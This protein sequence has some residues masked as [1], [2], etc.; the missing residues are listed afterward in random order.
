[1]RNILFIILLLTASA[2]P[3]AVFE[4]VDSDIYAFLERQSIRGL[5]DFRYEIK[6]VLKSL[7]VKELLQLSGKREELTSTDRDLLERYLSEFDYEAKMVTDKVPDESKSDFITP[8]TKRKIRLFEHT[9]GEFAMFADPMLE[10]SYRKEFDEFNFI[11][12]NGFR[13]HGY[14]MK[15]W[16]F[17]IRFF[18]N[19]EVTDKPDYFKY[20]KPERGVVITKKKKDAFEYDEVNASVTYEWNTGL[21]S[22][23]KDYFSIG[24]ARH[25]NIILSDKAPSFPFI[26][27]DFYPADWLRFLYFHGFL[28]SNIPDSSSFRFTMVP[29]RSTIADVPKFMAFHSLSFY[30]INEL[31]I[32]MGESIVYSEYIQPV[33]FIPVMFFRVADHYLGRTN[34]SASGNA[35]MFMDASY[36]FTRLNTKLY[37][38]LFIDELSLNKLFEGKNHSAIGYTAGAEIYDP[39]FANSSFCI[40]YTKISPFVYMNSVDAQVYSNEYYKLGHW[41]ESNADILS[42]S[43][44]QHIT[45]AV[46]LYLQGWYFRKGK[47][48]LPQEQYQTPYP[49]TF[50]GERRNDLSLKASVNY[51]PFHP[52]QFDAFYCYRNI[53]D[54]DIVRTPAGYGGTFNDFGIKITYGF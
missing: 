44:S 25:G 10:I 54:E 46:K 15:G 47:T 17:D 11:R 9:G 48:E 32:T 37:G 7:I 53:D 30:P 27:F 1:M 51:R 8:G 36:K 18:D 43:Y 5:S 12:R 45:G 28:V 39:V 38:S 26:R 19:E 23:G 4:P 2:L 35:Q 52:L 42:L 14:A 40:E 6:P 20:L 13:A 31:S 34:H 21:L 3:Q 50:Y 49:P 24:S 29:G 33:Y 41:I 22:L 16:G